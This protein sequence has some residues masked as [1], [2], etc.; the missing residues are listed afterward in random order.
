MRKLGEGQLGAGESHISGPLKGEHC[1]LRMAQRRQTKLSAGSWAQWEGVRV[2][3]RAQEI[4]GQEVGLDKS[5]LATGGQQR[6]KLL[7]MK[8]LVQWFHNEW[9]RAAAG[10]GLHIPILHPCLRF[11]SLWRDRV[12]FPMVFT[13]GLF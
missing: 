3:Q 9:K 8:Y 11:G 7:G 2:V 6:L 1:L 4:R 13:L 10:A 5:G 12:R